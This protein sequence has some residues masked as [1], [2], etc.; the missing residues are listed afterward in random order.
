MHK[1]SRLIPKIRIFCVLGRVK[2]SLTRINQ[3]LFTA[4]FSSGKIDKL[5]NTRLG[6]T[7]VELD[8][9]IAIGFETF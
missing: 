3:L 5:N 2:Y 7:S 4:K 6:K 8:I 9:K 1:I